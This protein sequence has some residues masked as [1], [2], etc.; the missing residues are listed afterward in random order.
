MQTSM[1][2]KGFKSAFDSYCKA[3]EIEISNP[4]NFKIAKR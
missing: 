3:V 4:G 1:T 2:E